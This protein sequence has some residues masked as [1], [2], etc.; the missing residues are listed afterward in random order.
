MKPNLRL[1][2]DLVLHLV[3]R[4]GFHSRSGTGDRYLWKGL[5]CGQLWTLYVLIGP[6]QNEQR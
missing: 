4:R 2:R 5:R 6:W 3:Q 1:S